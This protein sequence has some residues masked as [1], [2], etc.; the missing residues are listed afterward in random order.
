[1]TDDLPTDAKRLLS[2]L[3]TLRESARS[4]GDHDREREYDEQIRLIRQK[5]SD[6]E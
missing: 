4:V 3:M 6:G 5:Y 2:T 1:M